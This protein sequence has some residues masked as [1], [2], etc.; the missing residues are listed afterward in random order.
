MPISYFG[1][2]VAYESNSNWNIKILVQNLRGKM[3]NRLRVSSDLE[4]EGW[5]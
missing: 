3:R 5:F 2:F 1:M 4:I